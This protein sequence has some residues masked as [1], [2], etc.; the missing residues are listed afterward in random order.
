MDR[1]QQFGSDYF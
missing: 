1:E